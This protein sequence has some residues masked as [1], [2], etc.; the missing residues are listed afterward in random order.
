M[1]YAKAN[2]VGSNYDSRYNGNG[3]VYWTWSPYS[4]VA[5]EVALSF[6]FDVSTNSCCDVDHS[7]GGVRPAIA[8][9]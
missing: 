5:W 8:I 7:G 6:Y 9:K 3:M 4:S 2:G 1:V